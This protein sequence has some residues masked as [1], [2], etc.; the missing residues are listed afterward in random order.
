MIGRMR[1]L[2]GMAVRR[3]VATERHAARL[4]HA[5]MDPLRAGLRAFLA[6]V[7]FGVLDAVHRRD[8]ITACPSHDYLRSSSARFQCAASAPAVNVLSRKAVSWRAGEG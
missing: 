8:V 1:M 4:T 7:A 2:G 5:Q 6:D 3:R